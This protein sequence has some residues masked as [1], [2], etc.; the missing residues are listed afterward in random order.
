M[1][2]NLLFVTYR[3]DDFGDGLTYALDLAK[4][5]DRGIAILLLHKKRLSRKF[6]DLMSAITFAEVNEHETAREILKTSESKDKG[7]EVQHILEERCNGSGISATIYTALS[8]TVSALK[9]FLKQNHNI[10]MVLLSPSITDN[11][12]LTSKELNKLVRA[13]SRPIVTIAK[14]AQVA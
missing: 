12:N 4:M 2:R 7:D 14:N 13:A 8:D 9:D 11:G 3:D 6:E 1:K 10:E 5:M